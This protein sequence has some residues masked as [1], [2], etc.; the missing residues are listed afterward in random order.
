[1][2]EGI[3]SKELSKG[4]LVFMEII[5]PYFDLSYYLSRNPEVKLLGIDPVEHFVISGWKESRDPTP[6]FSTRGYLLH[7]PDVVAAGINPFLH[8]AVQCNGQQAHRSK[9]DYPL[10]SELDNLIGGYSYRGVQHA[11]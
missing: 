11:L 10:S 3:N 6:D 7:N 1:M 4:S 2:H 9:T 8:G 5:R